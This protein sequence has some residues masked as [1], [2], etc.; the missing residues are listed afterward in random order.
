MARRPVRA[1][2]TAAALT[3]ALAV[4]SAPVA[5]AHRRPAEP[6]PPTFQ[7]VSVHDPSVVT[8]G[9]EIWVFGSH[10][11]AAKTDGLLHWEKVAD[12]A[13]ADNPLF[14]DVRA[15]LAET[16]AWAQ[17]DTL[18]AADVIQLPDGRYAMYY[19][20]CKGDSPRSAMGVAV[21]DDV[22][23]PYVDQG[24]FLRS[25]MWDQPSD[26]VDGA[27]YDARVHPNTVDPDA[28]VDA[29]GTW[30]LVYGSYSGGIFILELDPSTGKP[31]AGQGYGKHLV[32]GNHSRIEGPT[33][34]YDTRTRYYYL[35][36]SFGGLDANG[37]YNVRVA[38]SKNPDGPYL[39]AAGNDMSQVKADP[40][41]P[42][43]DDASIEPFGTKILGNHLFAREVGDPG[44]GPGT[45]YLSP[46]HNSWYRDPETGESF[47]VFHSRFPGQG[48]QHEVRVHQMWMNAQG[49]PVL[50]P[51]RYAGGDDRR[52]ERKD[53]A[54][55]YAL[56]THDK[57]LTADQRRSTAVTLTAT[58]KVTGSLT[59]KWSLTGKNQARIDAGGTRYEGVFT[60]SWQPDQARWVVTFSVLSRDGVTLWGSAVPSLTAKQAVDAV[61]ADLDLGDTSGVVADLTL[62]TTGTHGTTITWASSDP[63]VVST[64]GD[65]TRPEAGAGDAH[66]T[67]TA[68]VRN[69]TAQ[70]A[71]TFDVTVLQRVA[72]GVVGSWS[73]EGDLADG[74][75]THA[76]AATTGP[77]IDQ[78]GGTVTYVADGARGQAAHLDGTSGVRLPDGLVSGSTWSASM[79]LRPQVLTPYTT[80]FFAA[81]DTNSWVS[82]VPR[83]HDGV[84]GSTMVWSGAQWYDAGTGTQIPVGEWSHVAVTVD[85]GDVVVYVD[86]E[87]RYTG[88]GFP[89]LLTTTTGAFALGVNWWDTPFQGDVDEVS[90]WSSA[91]TPTEVAALATR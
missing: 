45:G 36:L 72:G 54:G 44:E 27:I 75:G 15:N 86:G 14:D 5:Q 30:W 21:S 58:G 42:L 70:R 56:V 10:L 85:G 64:T 69:G 65:V 6:P 1:A 19:N 34:M 41:E 46:G 81:R 68:T 38:R 11:A 76:P 66:V 2:L 52:V 22:D 25:G 23:G 80:A 17:S 4:T 51:Y 47:L 49:W 79:W 87:A 89:D 59:G 37:A 62:P 40:T 20:A 90:V 35:F 77:R 73:F 55:E 71:A 16:F 18:W 67:L 24:I 43:F 78:A 3:L 28:F 84:G 29:Q 13:N 88:T 57:A 48:E 50:D 12:G 8:S 63:A 7:D 9:D 26:A 82:V 32:G 61:V 91:L 60:R 74:T 31:V 33:V 53:V 83:G 39:D